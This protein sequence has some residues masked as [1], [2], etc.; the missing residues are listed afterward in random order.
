MELERS[1]PA[2]QPHPYGQ[3]SHLLRPISDASPLSL[4]GN[5]VNQPLRHPIGVVN[6]NGRLAGLGCSR[7]GTSRFLAGRHIRQVY[8]PGPTLPLFKVHQRHL[9]SPRPN[10]NGILLL[11]RIGGRPRRGSLS[12]RALHCPP[13]SSVRAGGRCEGQQRAR[14]GGGGRKRGG[15]EPRTK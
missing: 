2:R 7:A 11:Q 3:S 6:R 9:P 14:G 13:Q 10:G 1:R 5:C 12:P 8:R 15:N 4:A